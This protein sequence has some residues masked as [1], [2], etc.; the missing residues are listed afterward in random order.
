MDIKQIEIDK[1]KVRKSPRK[2]QRNTELSQY[3]EQYAEETGSQT[4]LNRALSVKDCYKY[5]D[6]DHYVVQRI[7]D[8]K[9]IQLCKDKFC[10]NCQNVLALRRLSKYKPYLDDLQKSYDVYHVIF[11]VKNCPAH[12]L[13][14]TLDTMYAKF[15]Y[16]IQYLD[17]KRRSSD[18][19][20]TRFGYA[21]AVRS[22][23]ITTK[24]DDHGA[25]EYH[26]HFHCLFLF[27]KDLNNERIYINDFSFSHGKKKRSFSENEILLQKSWYLLY[28]SKRLNKKNIDSLKQ[29]FSVLAD[30]AKGNYHEVFKYAL[31]GTFK[32]NAP[33]FTY[34]VFKT[35]YKALYRRK[36]IQGYGL[37]NKFKFEDDVTEEEIE[38]LY[39]KI[40]EELRAV[41]KPEYHVSTLSDVLDDFDSD[42]VKYISR[43]SIRSTLHNND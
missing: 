43:N 22:L 6:I 42:T 31:K 8:V 10:N 2:L 4:L 14:A 37:L 16:L 12:D 20:F 32:D 25:V 7:K 11:T 39:Q 17:G 3:L 19:N 29:G 35:I 21:G 18:L 34:D 24:F 9:R 33:L 28:H 1:K 41:E 30:D 36:I 38:E 27:R 13:N 26:P 23:E 15:P 40:L 5:W